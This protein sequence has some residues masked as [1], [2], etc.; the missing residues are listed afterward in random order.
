MVAGVPAK[1][2]GWMSEFGERLNFNEEGYAHCLSTHTKYSLIDNCVT[3][4]K[5]WAPQ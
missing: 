5:E 4:E 1:H 3:K 2:I